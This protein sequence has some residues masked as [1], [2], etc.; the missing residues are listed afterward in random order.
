MNIKRGLFRLWIVITGAWTIVVAAF[1]YQGISKPYF[2]SRALY[3]LK[4]VSNAQK[5]A[6]QEQKRARSPENWGNFEISTPGG[7]VYTMRGASGED[8]YARLL[9][10]L[11]TASYLTAP[12]VTEQYGETYRALEEGVKRKASQRITI[13]EFPEVSLYV[14]SSTTEVEKERLV[15]FAYAT[16]KTLKAEVIR[17]RRMKGLQNATIAA[18]TPP[19]VLFLIGWLVIWIVRGFKR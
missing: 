18:I 19:A 10:S 12:E 11:Q 3:F 7:F 17:Q 2:P 13:H 9:A 4:D 15:D 6:E 14:D 8:A 16:A 5:Q 1:F